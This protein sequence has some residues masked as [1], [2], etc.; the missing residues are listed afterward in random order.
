MAEIGEQGESL[1]FSSASRSANFRPDIDRIKQYDP[2]QKKYVRMTWIVFGLGLLTAGFA[3]RLAATGH[4]IWAGA[5][6][7]MVF[8][9]SFFGYMI[10]RGAN[11]AI[12]SSGL[13]IPARVTSLKPLQMVVMA[14]MDTSDDDD[15]ERNGDEPEAVDKLNHADTAAGKGIETEKARDIYGVRRVTLTALPMHTLQIGERV[16]CAAGFGGSRAGVWSH[17]EPRPLVWATDEP[18]IIMASIAAIP[19]E[20]WARLD[21]LAS[22]LPAEMNEDQV[23][24]YDANLTFIEAK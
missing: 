20:E 17:F 6:G 1:N 18:T 14:N 21:Q 10:S 23:A 11:A 4:G 3:L 2:Y 9:I 7:V 16:P 13:L 24:F 12:Y 5:V 15:G 22:Q 19:D 8:V